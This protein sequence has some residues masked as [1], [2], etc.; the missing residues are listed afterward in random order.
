MKAESEKKLRQSKK[1]DSIKAVLT[2][3]TEKDQQKME[4][5]QIMTQAII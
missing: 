4:S 2:K 3:Q 1:A 5:Q